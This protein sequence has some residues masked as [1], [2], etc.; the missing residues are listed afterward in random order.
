M[1][2]IFKTLTMPFF[3]ASVLLGAPSFAENQEGGSNPCTLT[4]YQYL[5]VGHSSASL[6]CQDGTFEDIH[7]GL[8]PT[9]FGGGFDILASCVSQVRNIMHLAMA[10]SLLAA[11]SH[12]GSSFSQ[13]TGQ[14]L[15]LFSNA[16]FKSGMILDETPRVMKGAFAQRVD[17]R[18]S[19]EKALLVKEYIDK[20]RKNC[21]S[22]I[23]N[24]CRYAMIGRNCV[25]FVQELFNIAGSKRPF[26]WSY[27]ASDPPSIQNQVYGFIS[28]VFG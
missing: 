18:I 10:W 12:S 26:T 27:E 14:F 5:G 23:Q 22:W 20:V 11:M 3:V 2:R 19:K 25:D 6:T 1:K 21:D 13:N 16:A 7:V 8:Y 4:A 17:L 24:E 15:F 28:W 9:D